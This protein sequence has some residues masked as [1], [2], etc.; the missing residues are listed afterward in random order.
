MPRLDARPDQSEQGSHVVHLRCAAGGCAACTV[1][2]VVRQ[3]ASATETTGTA[4]GPRKQWRFGRSLSTIPAK[5]AAVASAP[6]ASSFWFTGSAAAVIRAS[7]SF[8]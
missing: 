2:A 4:R 1:L 7:Q 3:K 6:T 8:H 5:K